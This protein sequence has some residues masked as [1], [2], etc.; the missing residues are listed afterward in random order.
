MDH[1]SK[2]YKFS[3]FIPYL[4]PFS[5]LTHANEEINLWCEILGHI[6]YKYIFDLS[7]KDMVI[8]LPNIKFSKGVFQ[9]CILGKHP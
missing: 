7:D 4:N 8:G 5:L 3:H 9:G 6:N 1:T 2:V